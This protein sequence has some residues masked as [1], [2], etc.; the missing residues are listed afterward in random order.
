MK[1]KK[2]D[3]VVVLSGKDRG[4]EGAIMRVLP[5]KNKVIV[6]GV[7][8]VKKHQKAT[9]QAQQ[10]GIIERDMPIAAS[11]VA[12]LSPADGKPTRI[13]Y[14]IDDAGTKHRIC[15]RSGSDI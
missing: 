4:K 2:G 6:E 11:N 3:K 9:Q 14:R 13:G 5:E 15:R 7:N 10:G 1:L 12:I 8:V